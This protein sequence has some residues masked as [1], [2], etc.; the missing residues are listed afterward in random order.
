LTAIPLRQAREGA[1]AARTAAA[2]V[3]SPVG[4]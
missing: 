4:R 3:V 1:T 2:G